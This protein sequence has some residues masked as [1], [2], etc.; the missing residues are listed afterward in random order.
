MT[1]STNYIILYQQSCEN[2]SFWNDG[3]EDLDAI[4]PID[5]YMPQFDRRRSLKIRIF[6]L[7]FRDKQ[8]PRSIT[9]IRMETTRSNN[10][11]LLQLC[12]GDMY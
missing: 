10:R 6:K 12:P 9:I 2:R 5:L 7:T 8:E 4:S 11:L 1:L 3:L